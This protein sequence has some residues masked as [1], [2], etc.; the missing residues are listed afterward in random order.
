MAQSQCGA[1]MSAGECL[2]V[3]VQL[4]KAA[5]AS[6]GF[7][8]TVDAKA[9]VLLAGITGGDSLRKVCTDGQSL[10]LLDGKAWWYRL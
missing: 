2:S 4:P 5:L 9:T 3:A 10:C 6:P 7:N 1:F 8:A